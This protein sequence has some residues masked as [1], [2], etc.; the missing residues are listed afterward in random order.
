MASMQARLIF[1]AICVLFIQ[2]AKAIM[3]RERIE[4]AL[5]TLVAIAGM[6]MGG[7]L[8][9]LGRRDREQKDVRLVGAFLLVA[10]FCYILGYKIPNLF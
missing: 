8:L 1:A 7:L 3:S 10:G 9:F 6:F 4:M 5:Q 2:Q